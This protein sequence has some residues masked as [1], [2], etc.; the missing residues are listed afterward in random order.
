MK[1]HVIVS[2]EGH[3]CQLFVGF[4]GKPEG[5]ASAADIIACL[6]AN[7]EAAG[8]VLLALES[9]YI[10]GEMAKSQARAERAEQALAALRET[11]QHYEDDWQALGAVVAEVTG[12]D[13]DDITHVVNAAVNTLRLLRRDR[14][15]W[16]AK[17][18]ALETT[19]AACCE[20]MERERDEARAE[21][22][23]LSA[24]LDDWISAASHR[25]FGRVAQEPTPDR[26]RQAIEQAEALRARLA[27]AEAVVEAAREEHRILARDSARM[28]WGSNDMIHAMCQTSVALSALDADMGGDDPSRAEAATRQV[29]IGCGVAAVDSAG[30]VIWWEPGEPLRPT[31]EAPATRREVEEL[32]REVADLAR[33]LSASEGRSG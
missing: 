24:L 28:G 30:R 31:P 5:D 26:L 16:R 29:P 18:E 19:R 33:R 10:A 4:E 12:T 13:A 6:R 17:W 11:A 2:G 32:R 9:Q 8:Q 14:D 1:Y 27:K 3:D 22:K 21:R 25:S 23:R 15:T 7:P 20:Q